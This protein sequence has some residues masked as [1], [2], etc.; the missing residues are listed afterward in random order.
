MCFCKHLHLRIMHGIH[1]QQQRQG[2]PLSIKLARSAKLCASPGWLSI[3]ICVGFMLLWGVAFYS[4]RHVIGALFVR[5]AAVAQVG[6]SMACIRKV[7][8]D[9]GNESWIA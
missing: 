5:D 2:T 6:H 3:L 8:T 4:L 7:P 9:L 1:L